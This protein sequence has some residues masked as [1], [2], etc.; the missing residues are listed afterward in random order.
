VGV[1][2]P[3]DRMSFRT[4]SFPVALKAAISTTLPFGATN[5]EFA[6]RGA[7]DYDLKSTQNWAKF[8]QS[9]LTALLAERNCTLTVWAAEE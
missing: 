2:T 5:V 7:F 4:A 8:A 9:P 6:S 1:A 3:D